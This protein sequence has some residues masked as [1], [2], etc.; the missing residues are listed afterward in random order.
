MGWKLVKHKL[1]ANKPVP[2]WWRFVGPET[3]PIWAVPQGGTGNQSGTVPCPESTTVEATQLEQSWS[4][5]MRINALSFSAGTRQKTSL[6]D[7]QGCTLPAINL[8][9]IKV[10]GRVDETEMGLNFSREARWP[11]QDTLKPHGM[12]SSNQE[13]GVGG[14]KT[15]L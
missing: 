12:G 3:L 8:S 4:F 13:A 10:L 14:A 11:G 6:H 2:L 5:Q 1:L 7:C 15:I 9:I